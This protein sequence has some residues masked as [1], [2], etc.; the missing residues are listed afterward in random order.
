[1]NK[2]LLWIKNILFIVLISLIVLVSIR[3]KY[4]DFIYAVLYALFII[5]NLRD[6]IRKDKIN[7]DKLYNTITILSLI[8]MSFI[9][10]R[11]LY[12]SGFLHNSEI[13][14]SCLSS[15]CFRYIHIFWCFRHK[16]IF[17]S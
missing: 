6:I 12:D 11:V 3:F 9:Y 13:I 15:H 8:I 10:A 5:V 4:I 14:K 7:K 2:V 1:M 17:I 16:L